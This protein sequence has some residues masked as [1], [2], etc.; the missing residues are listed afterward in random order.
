MVDNT[1]GVVRQVITSQT[2][3]VQRSKSGSTKELR[4]DRHGPSTGTQFNDALRWLI[5]TRCLNHHRF[6]IAGQ[7]QRILLN[8]HQVI[9]RLSTTFPAIACQQALLLTCNIENQNHAIFQMGLEV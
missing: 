2:I 5:P 3:R 4:T 1:M 8:R 9:K 7:N 6:L